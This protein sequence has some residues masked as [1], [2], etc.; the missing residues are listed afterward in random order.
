MEDSGSESENLNIEE[1]KTEKWN[2]EIKNERK[3]REDY[4]I[5]YFTYLP[6]KCPQCSLNKIS[7]GTLNNIINPVILVCNNFKCLYG[8]NLR[9]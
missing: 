2:I 3:N 1:S 5:K 6:D 9:K 4:I 8:C 7:K